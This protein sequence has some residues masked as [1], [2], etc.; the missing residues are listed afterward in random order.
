M[1][2]VRD[3]LTNLD[4]VRN[5]PMSIQGLIFDTLEE[6]TNGTLD[7]V[8]ATNPAVFL[9]EAAACTAASIN[10]R[11]DV[12]YR[13]MSSQLA[14]TRED[15]YRHMSDEDYIGVFG[16]YSTNVFTMLIS[17]GDVRRLAVKD[18][19]TNTRKLV[20]PRG[21]RISPNNV[22]FTLQYPIEIRILPS[23]GIQI[24]YDT[25]EV[26]PIQTVESNVI[27]W[28]YNDIQGL[29]HLSIDFPVPQVKVTTFLD[30]PIAG[31]GYNQSIQFA[32]QFFYCRVF[33]VLE[34]NQ[35]EEYL[36]T[37][38]DQNYDPLRVT[39]VLQ[40]L[41]GRLRV[42]IPLIYLTK[43]MVSNQIRI[44]VYTTKGAMTVSYADYPLN[45]FPVEW[46]TEY[47]AQQSVFSS[48][49]ELVQSMAFFS[50]SVS[51]GGAPELT[52][53]ELRDRVI[54]G[55]SRRNK[56]ITDA[57]LT[58]TLR[59]LGY[60]VMKSKDTL[61]GRTYYATRGLPTIQGYSFS[62]GAACTIETL[63]SS[64]AELLTIDTVFN[65]GSRITIGSGTLFKY[66][67]DGRLQVVPTAQKPNPVT[68]GN[69]TVVN[70]LNNSVYTYNPFHYVL[71]SS[72][73]QFALRAF[74]LDA[75]RVVSRRFI[76]ENETTGLFVTTDLFVVTRTP[77]GYRLV[78]TTRSSAEYK[79]LDTTTLYA[80]LYFIPRG[81]AVGAYINGTLLGF[82]DDEYAWEFLLETKF[83]VDTN[84]ELVFNN[85]TMF[86]DEPRNV[87]AALTTQ[88]NVVYA[89]A[90]YTTSGL[91]T[92]DID[93][94]LGKHLL[95][96]AM[97]GLTEESL[98]IHLGSSLDRLWSNGRTVASS[99]TYE[100]YV[101][102]VFLTY[103][104][105][106]YR[107]S[108]SG[109]IEI[110]RNTS[111]GEFERTVVH[112]VGDIVND[113]D[114]NP[115][116]LYRK[117][118]TVV[119]PA[120]ELPIIS[121]GRTVLRQLDLLLVD[122]IYAYATNPSDVS[123]KQTIAS[124]I[125][126]FLENDIRRL[127][128]GMFDNSELFYY[129]S[130]NV[131]YI[132]VTA[133][134][135]RQ[136]LIPSSLSFTVR[137]YLDEVRYRD[138]KIRTVIRTEVSAVIGRLLKRQIVSVDELIVQ[139]KAAIG[140]DVVSID[141]DKLG[142]NRDISTFTINDNSSRASIRR[143]LEILPDTQLAVVEDVVVEFKRHGQ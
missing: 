13:G 137:C 83:D 8:D 32:D 3:L 111:T 97:V 14:T 63:Q 59:D 21:T 29:R 47:T 105:P 31:A 128:A 103:K 71:D 34:N 24:L 122:G 86:V 106:V 56:P 123:Y 143:V 22:T 95:P 79:A 16:T 81:E 5:N 38:T 125:V 102:D 26:S 18:G 133:D 33:G 6:I 84:D 132:S 66:S 15:L 75:P 129:P 115:I 50:T 7:V 119:D 141:V 52:F 134:A 4:L 44:D 10:L 42:Q 48:P 28:Y 19:A 139:L 85:F 2:G 114:G 104:T 107:K 17:E 110:I 135:Q 131:G 121:N 109:A 40:V 124:T 39:A 127:N 100:K 41:E 45:A 64:F 25:N 30:T 53:E 78:V 69:D 74:Y 73:N 99:V 46:G 120:T 55:N 61:T 112:Q 12:V 142:P 1:A 93:L 65:N 27:D 136:I 49:L 51:V 116:V 130:R 87:P 60:S 113:Q 92:T 70:V 77:T 23:N 82:L 80:Q 9:M 37:H 11:T 140:D 118:T 117:G 54:A 138:D 43:G 98:N 96:E 126:G 68:Q 58:S 35:Y 89:V 72:N 62:S 67:D 20:I 36:T 90:D 101:D 88:F 94:H 108:E 91:T 57:E 76:T